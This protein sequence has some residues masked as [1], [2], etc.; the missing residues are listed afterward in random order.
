MSNENTQN[1]VVTNKSVDEVAPSQNFANTSTKTEQAP[2][3]VPLYIESKDTDYLNDKTKIFYSGANFASEDIDSQMLIESQNLQENSDVNSKT[4]NI[5][6]PWERRFGDAFTS[7]QSIGSDMPH[8]PQWVGSP[9]LLNDYALIRFAHVANNKHH[10]SLLDNEGDASFRTYG[11]YKPAI[12]MK[13]LENSDSY[14]INKNQKVNIDGEEYQEIDKNK[15]IASGQYIKDDSKQNE[16]IYA[17]SSGNIFSVYDDLNFEIWECKNKEALKDFKS[18]STEDMQVQVIPNFEEK[19]KKNPELKQPDRPG[20]KGNNITFDQNVAVRFWALRMGM[21]ECPQLKSADPN[22]KISGFTSGEIC[23]QLKKDPTGKSLDEASVK[24]LTNEKTGAIP[25]T[26]KKLK[27]HIN[28]QWTFKGYPQTRNFI[29]K[30][31]TELYGIDLEEIE[32]T[33]ENLCNIDNWRG[34]EQF[35]YKWA[36]FMYCSDFGLAPNNRLI[37]LRRYPVAVFDHGRIP[38]QDETY[39]YMLPVAKAVT[40]IGSEGN[41]T[42]ETLSSFS[43]KMNWKDL[44]ADVETVSTDDQ[45]QGWDSARDN[46]GLQEGGMMDKIGKAIGVASGGANF[47]TISGKADQMSKFDPYKDGPY[48]NLPYGPVNV[49][50]RVV[51]RDR[52]LVFDHNITLNFK[53][54]LN[55]VGGVNPKAALLDIIANFLALTYNNAP[56]WGGAIRYFQNTPQYPFLGGKKGMESWYNG[57]IHGFVDAIGDQFTEALSNLGDMLMDLFTNPV[58]AIKK[59]GTQG[60]KLWMAKKQHGKRPGILGFKGLLTGES[61]GEWHLMV[62]NPFNPILMIGNLV[63]DGAK[64]QF[65][66]TL[67]ADDFPEWVKFEV[68]LKHARPRD[69]GDIESM[70]NRGQGRLHYAYAGTKTEPWNHEIDSKGSLKASD[71][72]SHN[73]NDQGTTVMNNDNA[74]TYNAEPNVQKV[75]QSPT[76][77]VNTAKKYKVD[78]FTGISAVDEIFATPFRNISKIYGQGAKNAARL[79]EKVGQKNAREDKTD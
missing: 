8:G 42:M 41:N 34:N 53:Y 38:T 70:L 48:A 65:A 58:A 15:L 63:V 29:P 28:A 60:A 68:T 9:S 23:E 10:K 61:T 44:V 62:G 13:D 47:D 74:T 27:A 56:F 18:E 5:N 51:I 79:A 30:P 33:Y 12:K 54:D 43:W 57:D 6:A 20:V 72:K 19:K 14:Y 73:K 59:L 7:T 31:G 78:K 26:A 1:K 32:P 66:E 76:N 36:D 69:K 46:L 17:D 40:W 55:S 2:T 50:D 35:M 21:V 71:P 3:T 64:L 77:K 16:K 37:T 25:L 67:G 22:L 4:K 39:K 24:T 52:G 75:K 11:S 49:I 45:N